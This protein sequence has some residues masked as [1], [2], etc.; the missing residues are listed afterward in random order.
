MTSRLITGHVERSCRCQNR[1]RLHG[2]TTE[3]DRDS[4]TEF[5]LQRNVTAD[6]FSDWICVM[7]TSHFSSLS[8]DSLVEPFFE[9]D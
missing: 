6:C 7:K 2:P 9:V 3:P 8:E 1:R 5:D 4:G